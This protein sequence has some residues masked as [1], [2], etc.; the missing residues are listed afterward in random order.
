MR[1]FTRGELG[2]I[3]RMIAGVLAPRF[4]GPIR[5]MRP[6]RRLLDPDPTHGKAT[7]TGS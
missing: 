7:M 2:G 5:T 6:E 3:V 4:A 1:P